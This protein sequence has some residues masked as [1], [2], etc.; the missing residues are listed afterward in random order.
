MFPGFRKKFI[1]P[2]F[3]PKSMKGRI[4][5]IKSIHAIPLKSVKKSSWLQMDQ[6]PKPQDSKF[7]SFFDTC[8]HHMNLQR[9][10]RWGCWALLHQLDSFWCRQIVARWYPQPA[11]LSRLLGGIPITTLGWV[12]LPILFGIFTRKNGGNDPIRQADFSD[13]LVQPPSRWWI[14]CWRLL[15]QQPQAIC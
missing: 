3:H 8:K 15:L 12:K 11:I 7:K 13:G 6:S 1:V 9:R 2:F 10:W 4:R 5:H 14:S